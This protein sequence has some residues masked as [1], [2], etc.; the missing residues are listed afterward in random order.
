ML[1]NYTPMTVAEQYYTRHGRP[2][3]KKECERCINNM[4]ADFRRLKRKTITFIQMRNC[5]RILCHD[6]CKMKSVVKQFMDANNRLPTE[7]ERDLLLATLRRDLVAL[8]K[9]ASGLNPDKFFECFVLY[10]KRADKA[11]NMM[12]SMVKEFVASHGRP[13]NAKERKDLLKSLIADLGMPLDMITNVINAETL[14]NCF[15][16]YVH[17]CYM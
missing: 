7:V 6:S 14:L 17:V 9:D 1:V 12:E 13:A 8:E 3:N 10:C 16:R 4:N 5:F 15:R 2:A 11:R